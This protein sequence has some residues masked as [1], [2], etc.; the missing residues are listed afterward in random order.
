MSARCLFAFVLYWDGIGRLC[1]CCGFANV[2]SMG[3]VWM[4]CDVEEW[5]R[6]ACNF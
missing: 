3:L 5:V 6:C 4:G 2:R 1:L